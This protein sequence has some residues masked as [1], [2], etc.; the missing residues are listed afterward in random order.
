MCLAVFLAVGLLALLAAALSRRRQPV[1]LQR[2]W[3]L[4][5]GRPGPA[6]ILS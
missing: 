3:R 4:P 1:A 5:G 2:G 6:A